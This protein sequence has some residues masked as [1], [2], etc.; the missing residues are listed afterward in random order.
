M[1]TDVPRKRWDDSGTPLGVGGWWWHACNN[2]RVDC[3]E[4]GFREMVYWID[5]GQVSDS[6]DVDGEHY[7]PRC[8]FGGKLRLADFVRERGRPS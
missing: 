3:P 6:G 5:Q 7:C 4:C 2:Y 8:N 1:R